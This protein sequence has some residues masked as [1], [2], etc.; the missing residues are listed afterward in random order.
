VKRRSTYT[1]DYPNTSY[2]RREHNRESDAIVL[3]FWEDLMEGS[4]KLV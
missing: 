4:E 1:R 3:E 2:S